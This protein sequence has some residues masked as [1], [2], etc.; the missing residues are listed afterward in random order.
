M[1]KIAVLISTFNGEKYLQQQID[2]INKQEFNKDVFDLQI[3]I[4]DDG[5]RDKTLEIIKKNESNNIIHWID[6]KGVNVG[7]RKSFFLLLKKVNADFYFFCDQDDIWLSPKIDKFMRKFGQINNE[8]PGGVYSDLL[9][10]D[11]DNNSLGQSMMQHNGWSYSEKRDFAKLM[12]NYRVTGCAFA[13]NKSA[14]DVV[15]SV[16]ISKFA[17]VYMHDVTLSQLASY[18]DNLHFL[19][20]CLVRYR[21]HSNNVLGANKV[22]KKLTMEEH[23]RL[24]Q[25]FF[26]DVDLIHN[27]VNNQK[28]QSNQNTPLLDAFHEFINSSKMAGKFFAFRKFK[29]FLKALTLKQFIFMLVFY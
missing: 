29:I 4:R 25:Q 27:M 24:Y 28:V 14:R 16:G 11:A 15:L 20:E 7:I 1:K 18:F 22:E 3:Y 12:L 23:R 5:S 2:S 10:V 6:S 8:I 17:K 9:L 19:P 26:Y 21:Q 13:V